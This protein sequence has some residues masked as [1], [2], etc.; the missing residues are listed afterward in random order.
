MAL[1]TET[2]DLLNSVSDK[3]TKVSDELSRK[4]EDSMKEIKNL[5]TLSQDTKN[6]VDKLATEQ[7]G[8][9]GQVK[10]LKAQ[11]DE[12]EQ[13]SVRRGG[14][15]ATKRLSIGA[16][17]VASEELKPFASGLRRG[18]TLSVEVQNTTMTSD[19]PAGVVEPTRL[20]EIVTS[21]KRRLFIK[22]LIG[23][24]ET[25]SNAVF[26][27]KQT[28][29][30][31]NARAVTEGQK[32]PYSNITFATEITAVATIAHMF[33]AAKQILDDFKQLRSTVDSELRYGLD[34]EEDRQILFGGGGIE[35]EG[36]V[37]QAQ[38]FDPAFS[39]TDQTHIDDLRLAM[40]QSQL[41]RLPASAFVLHFMDW[42]KI[43]LTK[44]SLGRYILANPQS[45]L[46]PTLWG[47]PVVPTDVPEFEGDFLTGPFDSGAQLFEREAANVVISTENADD[48]DRN[49]ISIRC[50]KRSVLAVKRPEGF[51]TGEFSAAA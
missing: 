10:D 30:T 41:A 27:V 44:D 12:V 17:L 45:L 47:L 6:E 2:K 32:K 3:L 8:L 39:V 21:P 13:K 7:T 43:E 26:W 46:G 34:F 15:E 35:L 25:D 14:P 23:S 48:F 50:E 18:Q 16:Q 36:I 19:I 20:P 4:A 29:F 9:A 11:L 38:D 33:K 1:D 5:G 31:N 40:L 28:G 42:A 37:P 49:L 51:I 24:G 22:S